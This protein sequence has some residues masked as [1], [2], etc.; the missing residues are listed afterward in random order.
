[1]G[2]PDKFETYFCNQHMP[3]MWNNCEELHDFESW[4][5]E[6][7]KPNFSYYDGTSAPVCSHFI[8]HIAKVIKMFITWDK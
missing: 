8:T 5:S 1:M 7:K 3:N 6:S 2:K 4:K